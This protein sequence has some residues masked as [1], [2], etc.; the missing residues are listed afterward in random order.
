[1]YKPIYKNNQCLEENNFFVNISKYFVI[2]LIIYVQLD[3]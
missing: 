2:F 3:A 1:M